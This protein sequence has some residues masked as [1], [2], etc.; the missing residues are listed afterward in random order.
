MILSIFI[1]SFQLKWILSHTHEELDY[2]S[3]LLRAYNVIDMYKLVSTCI[4]ILFIIYN[5]YKKIYNDDGTMYNIL[6]LPMNRGYIILS[7][8]VEVILFVL[9]Q[10]ILVYLAPT[11]FF[12]YTQNLLGSA[13][14]IR[15]APLLE[16][17]S[18]AKSA[19][20]QDSGIGLFSL[21]KEN[22]LYRIFITW[23]T[24]TALITLLFFGIYKYKIKLLIAFI[25]MLVLSLFLVSSA[26]IIFDVIDF[27]L[28]N[29]F[30]IIFDS[31]DTNTSIQ[32]IFILSIVTLI[33]IYIYRNKLDF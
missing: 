11:I 19:I 26:N 14:F 6:Q 9:I 33:N 25:S 29:F 17:L 15:F 2:I 5:L 24:I 13:E 8:L 7:L 31:F 32:S 4:I 22:V 12:K 23:P 3:D 10:Y 21:S 1:S 20:I 27:I 28:K 30:L 18:K 16:E